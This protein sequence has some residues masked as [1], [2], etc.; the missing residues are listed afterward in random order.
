MCYVYV[1]LYLY[2][3]SIF[4]SY[5]HCIRYYDLLFYSYLFFSSSEFSEYNALILGSYND[6][7]LLMDFQLVNQYWEFHGAH[8]YDRKLDTGITL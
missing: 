7:F 8:F 2:I 1:Y 3:V 4:A 5:I 6:S